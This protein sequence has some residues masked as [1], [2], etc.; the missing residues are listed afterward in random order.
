MR[1]VAARATFRVIEVRAKSLQGG[2][3]AQGFRPGRFGRRVKGGWGWCVCAIG[4]DVQ[5]PERGA[6]WGRGDGVKRHFLLVFF[7]YDRALIRCM[8][9][10]LQ[11]GTAA[12]LNA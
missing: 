10:D 4:V 12:V 8:Y 3:A 7:L 5:S 11:L 9:A 2:F 1:A 6:W